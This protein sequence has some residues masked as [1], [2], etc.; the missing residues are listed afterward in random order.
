MVMVKLSQRERDENNIGFIATNFSPRLDFLRPLNCVICS[1][2][3]FMGFT[4]TRMVVTMQAWNSYK[5]TGEEKFYKEYVESKKTWRCPE[6]A[7]L[8]RITEMNHI[9]VLEREAID[10]HMKAKRNYEPWDY[11][12]FI[13][14]KEA[15]PNEQLIVIEVNPVDHSFYFSFG[16]SV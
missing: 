16:Y 1:P 14:L 12:D 4:C 10:L 8:K 5:Q 3:V 13:L 15:L 2:P 11:Y 7:F 6:K 9:G